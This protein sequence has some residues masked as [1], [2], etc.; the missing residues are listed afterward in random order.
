MNDFDREFREAILSFFA[1]E[2]RD[3]PWRRTTDP[4]AILVSEFMLQQTQTSRVAPKFEAWMRR[5]PTPLSLAQASLREAL[6]LWSGLGYNR[7]CIALVEA[8]KSIVQMGGVP[9]DEDRLLALP[10]VGP[11][12]ARAVRAFAFGMPGIVIETNIRTVIIHFYFRGRERVSDREIAEVLDRLAY[13]DPRTWYWALMDYGAALKREAGNA[14]RRSIA[15]RRQSKFAGSTR[16][17]RGAVLKL[18][19]KDGATPYRELAARALIDKSRVDAALEALERE[20]I[21][22][23]EGD[24]VRIRERDR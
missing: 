20:G 13:D 15:Y 10:G 18:L 1:S 24:L 3:F 23:H 21:V 7:R 17:A 2:G 5:F 9:S 22:V 14:S 11:Y 4:W 16:Q 12:T 6:E 19:A 8:A